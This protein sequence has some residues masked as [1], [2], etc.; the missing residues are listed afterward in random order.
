[1][2]LVLSIGCK[3]GQK[4]CVR[5]MNIA[6]YWNNQSLETTVLCQSNSGI[7]RHDSSARASLSAEQTA[8]GTVK[9]SPIFPSPHGAARGPP[10]CGYD[11]EG[12]RATNGAT[13][14]DRHVSSFEMQKN[15]VWRWQSSKGLFSHLRNADAQILSCSLDSRQ[16]IV[17]VQGSL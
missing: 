4:F 7:Q 12:G 2:D 5:H 9:F 17:N 8:E 13:K 15:R 1:M 10:G 3:S 6:P 14:H 16:S 11:E